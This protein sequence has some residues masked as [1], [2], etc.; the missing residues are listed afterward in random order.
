MVN[1]PSSA[2]ASSNTSTPMMPSLAKHEGCCCST[3]NENPGSTTMTSVAWQ[4]SN[5][6]GSTK[7]VNSMGSPSKVFMMGCGTLGSTKYSA[8]SQDQSNPQVLDAPPQLTHH[9]TGS[10]AQKSVQLQKKSSL[11]NWN[12]MHPSG[13][14]A[15]KLWPAKTASNVASTGPVASGPSYTVTKSCPNPSM[16][17]AVK[18]MVIMVPSPGLSG[19]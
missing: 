6:T 17:P 5:P 10:K 19:Q 18:L 11:V 2:K 16:A 4:L 15:V 7:S 1:G 14:V 13:L 3:S 9:S 8:G 12:E